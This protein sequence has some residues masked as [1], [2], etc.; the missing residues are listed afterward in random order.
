[1]FKTFKERHSI[2][3]PVKFRSPMVKKKRSTKIKG[4]GM[5]SPEPLA[6]SN[7]PREQSEPPTAIR[8]N[9]NKTSKATMISPESTKTSGEE[10][11]PK[12]PLSSIRE[13]VGEEQTEGVG[14]TIPSSVD[15][16]VVVVE[17]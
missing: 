14:E 5:G 4:V 7:P 11:S 3:S 13:E 9:P 17:S 10:E 8:E 2:R 1:M 12:T 16:P 6:A 15:P